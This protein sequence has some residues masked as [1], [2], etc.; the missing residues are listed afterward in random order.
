MSF[1]VTV[2]LNY[3]EE[4]VTTTTK[5]RPLGTRGVTPDGRVFYY[6]QAGGSALAAGRCVQTKVAHGAS[7]HANGLTI[8]NATATGVTTLSITLATTNA[9]R[10]LY[11]DGYVVVDTSPGQSMWKVKSHPAIASAATGEFTF[12]GNDKIVDALTSGTTLVGLRENPYASTIVAPTTATGLVVGVPQ[13]AVAAGSYFWA[14]T[15]GPGLV[16]AD[17]APVAGQPVVSPG[18]SAGGVQAIT[19]AAAVENSQVIGVAQTAAG[20]ADVHSYIFLTIRA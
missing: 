4:K 20:G 8:V 1:P 3:G 9:S 6:A 16:N 18:A 19:T 13:V 11:A 17:T 7:V 14:Q 5:R 2:G 10:D 15:Y 12:Y